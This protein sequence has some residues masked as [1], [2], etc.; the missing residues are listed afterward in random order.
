MSSKRVEIFRSF[1]IGDSIVLSLAGDL[2]DGDFMG[3][4]D[5]DFSGDFDEDFP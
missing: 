1:L 3:D 4:F 5:G 2:F